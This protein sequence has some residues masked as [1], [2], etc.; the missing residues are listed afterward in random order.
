VQ[1]TGWRRRV[2]N[3]GSVTVATL[4]AGQVRFRYWIAPPSSRAMAA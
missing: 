1:V 3:H 4:Q 2:V